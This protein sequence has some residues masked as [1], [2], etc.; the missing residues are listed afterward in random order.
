MRTTADTSFTCI[1][2]SQ[3]IDGRERTKHS[4]TP[5]EV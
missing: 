2:Y 3:R 1:V 4:V 5:G